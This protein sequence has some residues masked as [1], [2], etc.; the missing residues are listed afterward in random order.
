MKFGTDARVLLGMNC[1]DF[2]DPYIFLHRDW[3]I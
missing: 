3:A 1:D 2:V